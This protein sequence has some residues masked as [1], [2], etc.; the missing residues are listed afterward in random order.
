MSYKITQ[1]TY[2]KAKQLN[3]IVEP[4]KNKRYKIDIYDKHNNYIT[5]IG[6]AHALDYPSYLELERVGVV[7]EGYANERRRL[8]KLRHH[9]DLAYMRGWWANRL[10]W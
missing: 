2:D 4:S 1:Y 7:P 9:K 6:Q 10:L 5:S 3:V 8:Y